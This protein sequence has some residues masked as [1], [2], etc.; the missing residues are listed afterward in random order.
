MERQCVVCLQPVD[1]VATI[2]EDAS[3]GHFPMQFHNEPPVEVWLHYACLTR[4]DADAA[5]P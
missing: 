4:S 3:G 5:R 1:P 2:G